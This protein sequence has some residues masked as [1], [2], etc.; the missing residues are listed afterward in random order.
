MIFLN[1]I[2][3]ILSVVSIG[4]KARRRAAVALTSSFKLRQ[5]QDWHARLD[6]HSGGRRVQNQQVLLQDRLRHGRHCKGRVRIH[7]A[8]QIL[9]LAIPRSPRAASLRQLPIRQRRHPPTQRRSF[10]I[11][12]EEVTPSHRMIHS[13]IVKN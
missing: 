9:L 8:A 11:Q 4:T 13:L 3:L 12:N 1:S 7:R 5:D 2:L 6:E 10:E